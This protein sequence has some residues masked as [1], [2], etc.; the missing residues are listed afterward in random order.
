[1]FDRRS[2]STRGPP[3]V[4]A[5][6]PTRCSSTCTPS[7]RVSPAPG[8][9][10]RACWPTPRARS[11][12]ASAAQR[13]TRAARAVRLSTRTSAGSRSPRPRTTPRSSPS[14]SARSPTAG[15]TWRGCSTA[16]RTSPRTSAARR[17]RA[18]ARSSATST[19]V[20][21]WPRRSAAPLSI[22]SVTPLQLTKAPSGVGARASADGR[23]YAGAVHGPARDGHRQRHGRFGPGDP[24][25]HAELDP[26][27]LGH[28]AARLPRAERRH[29]VP[30]H[31]TRRR[32]ASPPCSRTASRVHGRRPPIALARGVPRWKS[33]ANTRGY[34]VTPL[35]RP[36]GAGGAHH[37]PAP[38]SSAPDAGPTLAV[39]IAR[40]K[41]FSRVS[42]TA[43]ITPDAAAAQRSVTI[44]TSPS[45][46][47]SR[48]STLAGMRVRWG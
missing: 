6:S 48:S 18:S 3:T 44:P 21:C 46:F 7:R 1:M 28:H 15:S 8:S 35:S 32:R 22:R 5:A 29:P 43:R 47:H 42:F 19:A 13:S 31:R 38:Q 36:A 26:D 40:N 23:A 41:R 34:T 27:A 10:R 45:S 11:T 16:S 9:A 25:V 4:T 30:E 37:A 39:Q 33:R 20:A 12:P 24:P 17:P 2:S 14:T